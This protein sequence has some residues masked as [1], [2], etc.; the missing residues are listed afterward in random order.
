MPTPK[1]HN[2]VWWWNLDRDG[3]LV[4]LDTLPERKKDAP[5]LK[6][7]SPYTPAL[8][9]DGKLP[10]AHLHHNNNEILGIHGDAGLEH[11][12]LTLM[13]C[14]KYQ[15]AIIHG[16]SAEHPSEIKLEDVSVYLA[17]RGL[18]PKVPQYTPPITLSG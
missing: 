18:L 11:L 5:S 13:F 3:N 17:I 14:L 9:V 6:N 7:D 1:E 4:D 2:R 15:S 12:R 10:Q 8:F 16:L